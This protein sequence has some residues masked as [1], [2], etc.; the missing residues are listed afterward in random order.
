[1]ILL[2]CWFRYQS[3]PYFL[4]VFSNPPIGMMVDW[5]GN[6]TAQLSISTLFL[7][8]AHLLIYTKA[9]GAIIPLMMIG[10]SFRLVVLT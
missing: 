10:L 4:T 6:R 3:I 9:V 5:F 8:L 1:M 7:M 2:M